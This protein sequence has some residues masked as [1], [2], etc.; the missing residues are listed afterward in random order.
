MKNEMIHCL[1]WCS[2]YG[3]SLSVLILSYRLSPVAVFLFVDSAVYSLGTFGQVWKDWHAIGCIFVGL[4]NYFALDQCFVTTAKEKILVCNV[5]IYG[6]WGLQNLYYCITLPNLFVKMM[7]LHAVLC[8]GSA[9][10]CASAYLKSTN[11]DTK[12][13]TEEFQ[14]IK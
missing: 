6:I 7:W 9:T 11:Q 10:W 13:H 1:C 8:L 14:K 4:V 3:F 5:M 12:V 2:F